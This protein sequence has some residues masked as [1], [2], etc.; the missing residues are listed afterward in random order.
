[1]KSEGITALFT[2]LSGVDE[3]KN[4]DH[5]MA[6]LMDSWIALSNV[7][8]NGERNRILFLLKARGMGHSNQLREYEITS[9]GVSIIPAYTGAGNVPVGSAR[10]TQEAKERAE[11]AVSLADNE[12]RL[13]VLKR[14]RQVVERQIEEMKGELEESER[15]ASGHA[16]QREL[17]QDAITFDRSVMD[18]RR[19]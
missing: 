2:S 5:H 3:M 4:D 13:R 12:R 16:A 17:Q 7:S 9:D 1:M 11:A 19:N 8:T 10:V 14:R 18:R 6:S 15:E